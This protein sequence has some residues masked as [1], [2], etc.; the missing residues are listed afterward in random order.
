ML[1]ANSTPIDFVITWV[2]GSDIA[3]QIEK[4]KFLHKIPKNNLSKWN[5]G[6]TRYRDWGLMKYWFRG[7][8]KF[9]PWV[10]KI[11]FVTCGQI[12]DWLDVTHPKL[13]IV[14][15]KDY[16]PE[17]FLPTFKSHCIELNFHRINGLS[18]Q[19]V[20]FNDDMFLT[21]KVKPED[22]FKNGLPC[23]TAILA[24]I[25]LKQNGIRAEINNL[26]I[27][28]EYF[29]KNQVIKKNFLK[30]FSLLYGAN[31]IKTFLLLPFHYF[32]GFYITHLPC[33][34]LKKTYEEVWEKVPHILEETCEHR[35]RDTTDVNQWLFEYWQL[36]EGVFCP[37]NPDI[38]K[39]Y[40]GDGTILDMCN[41]I[42]RQKYK[43]ICFN[44]SIDINNFEATKKTVQDAFDYI[45]QEKSSYERSTSQ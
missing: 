22:F 19:F 34:Y 37:R 31:I 23:D 12:P 18:E 36:V 41:D 15:H 6:K 40:E 24:P 2:D 27:I 28:N 16:I 35:F 44:D 43:M 11:Y 26:Y 3:W 7:V 45:L 39:M 9:A 8:E 29:Q 38:G 1:K 21:K 4:E 33:S 14:N 17:K 32:T 20:Y 25:F 42:Q 10:H 30:W 13:Q 5:T